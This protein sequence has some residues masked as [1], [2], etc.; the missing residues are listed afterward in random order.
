MQCVSVTEQP[1]FGQ[2]NFEE[3]DAADFQ[4]DTVGR[5]F[6]KVKDPD[7]DANKNTPDPDRIADPDTP[8][9]IDPDSPDIV[10]PDPP[11]VDW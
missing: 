4:V 10:D 11:N 7:R 9:I 6:A 8:D 1:S 2:N 3:T 5:N